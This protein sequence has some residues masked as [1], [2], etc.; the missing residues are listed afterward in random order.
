[1]TLPR[2]RMIHPSVL[3]DPGLHPV[4]KR[5]VYIAAMMLAEDSGCL[6]WKPRVLL[7]TALPSSPAV[8]EED[9]RGFMEE[10]E[11]E[12][13]VW[14]YELDG[15]EYA[16]LPAF[17]EWQKSLTRFSVPTSVPLPPG[18]PFM[19]IESKNRY[20]SCKYLW[21]KTKSEML[22]NQPPSHTS[23]LPSMQSLTQGPA[24]SR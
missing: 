3:H 23:T 15:T 17:P 9:V 2:Q 19:E 21:P 14:R 11:A 24:D 7:R 10:L 22:T 20:G 1:M 5:L 8:S 18:I 6:L 12:G 4:E 16:F 13:Y